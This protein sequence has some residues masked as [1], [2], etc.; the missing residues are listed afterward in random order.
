MKFRT[1]TGSQLP[2][3][4]LWIIWSQ[5]HLVDGCLLRI[6]GQVSAENYTYY[7]FSQPGTYV[8]HLKSLQ[9]DADIYVSE[10]HSHPTFHAD[11]H[12]LSSTTCG[13]DRVEIPADFRRPVGIG[14]YGAFGYE[15]TIYELCFAEGGSEM[16]Y[17]H[18]DPLAKD[19]F[20]EQDSGIPHVPHLP[21]SAEEESESFLW[22]LFLDFI[23]ILLEFIL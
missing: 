6:T 16:D 23:R 14:I 8:L 22:T 15:T 21:K 20:S 13:D 5:M 10:G 12:Q 18:T 17:F 1:S 4:L 3:V 19:Y 2:F 11:D 7:S 9:G